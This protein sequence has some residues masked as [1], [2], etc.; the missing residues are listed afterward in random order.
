VRST[1]NRP[2]LLLVQRGDR[3]IYLTVRPS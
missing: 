3:A 1:P 2:V